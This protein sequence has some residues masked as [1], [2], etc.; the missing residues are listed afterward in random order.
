MRTE[1]DALLFALMERN[2]EWTELLTAD[3]V[4]M[5]LLR[6]QGASL[7]RIAAGWG[8]TKAGVRL[9]LYG[10]GCGK[11]RSGGVLGQLRNLDRRKARL[12]QP[13]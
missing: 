5:V 1:L 10:N 6:Q 8:M 4:Q 12:P 2:P 11:R 7:E 13:A 3:E 9:R